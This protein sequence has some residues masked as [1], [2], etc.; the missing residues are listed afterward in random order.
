MYWSSSVLH[1]RKHSTLDEQALASV[2][3]FVI[4]L[5]NSQTYL[6]YNYFYKVKSLE[7]KNVFALVG[8]LPAAPL[9]VLSQHNLSTLEWLI[10]LCIWLYDN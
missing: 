9:N 7:G 10:L 8:I 5:F 6:Q 2:I 1:G 3:V 4:I